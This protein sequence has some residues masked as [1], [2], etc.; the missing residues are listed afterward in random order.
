MN[1]LSNTEELYRLFDETN[2]INNIH[3]EIERQI[4]EKLCQ[5][6]PHITSGVA[7]MPDNI[8]DLLESDS[9]EEDIQD[10]SEVPGNAK[11]DDTDVNM[12]LHPLDELLLVKDEDFSPDDE[13]LLKIMSLAIQNGAPP[14]LVTLYPNGHIHKSHVLNFIRTSVKARKG[15]EIDIS[16]VDFSHGYQASDPIDLTSPTSLD[17][18]HSSQDNK[19][20]QE[21]VAAA[22][23]NT[24]LD[25]DPPSTLRKSVTNISHRVVSTD[26]KEFKPTSTVNGNMKLKSFKDYR[27]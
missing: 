14:N 9:D 18:N 13:R 22:T 7:R 12:L 23:T 17:T 6:D 19:V 4:P 10:K 1:S 26:S 2:E 11:K 16:V 5:M 15:L 25:E 21:T 20:I 24:S 3:I 27:E 8:I